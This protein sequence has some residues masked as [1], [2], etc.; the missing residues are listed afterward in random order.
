MFPNKNR[1]GL[2]CSSICVWIS[3]ILK[4]WLLWYRMNDTAISET[5]K[6]QSPCNMIGV[7][8]LNMLELS[9]EMIPVPQKIDQMFQN[10]SARKCLDLYHRLANEFIRFMGDSRSAPAPPGNQ[11]HVAQL[12]KKWIS[13]WCHCAAAS[14]WKAHERASELLP[15]HPSTPESSCWLCLKDIKLRPRWPCLF[16]WNQSTPCKSI[17]IQPRK[18]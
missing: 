2:V 18:H 15:S 6:I 8:T 1:R 12:Q 16:L 7:Q 13:R 17:S 3:D 9:S 4:L 14:R 5:R 11:L 10:E